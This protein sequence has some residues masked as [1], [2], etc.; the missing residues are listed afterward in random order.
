MG[1]GGQYE[2]KRA[3]LRHAVRPSVFAALLVLAAASAGQ[4]WADD[5]CP[6][7]SSDIDTDRPDTTNSSAVVPAG[8]LQ[9]ENGINL[10]TWRN[11]TRMDGGNTRL[12]LGIFDCGEILVDLPNYTFSASGM[13]LYG[14]SDVTPAAKIQLQDLPQ[15]L[16]ASL[17]GGVGLPSGTP[18]IAGKSYNPYLQIPWSQEIAEGW[19]IHGMFT[20]TWLTGQA[21]DRLFEATLSLDH[22]FSTAADGFIE[23]VGDY[24]SGVIPS[25][26]MDFGA[27]Y[28]IT[29]RQQVDFRAGFGL[30]RQ[31]PTA[32]FGIGYSFRADNLI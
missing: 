4:A 3:G 20:Q 30:T 26:V 15:G 24:L 12:R 8:S 19:G 29:P 2:I 22:D 31:A 13:H 27:A 6:A 28:R 21:S 17:V 18:A 32:F 16:Q 9:D 10:T 14:F 7:S 5:A 23:Y 25:Q 11:G 1:R